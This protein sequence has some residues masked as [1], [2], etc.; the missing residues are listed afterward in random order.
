[1]NHPHRV[2]SPLVPPSPLRNGD[3]PKK[4]AELTIYSLGAD[5]DAIIPVLRTLGEFSLREL[6]R[7]QQA[8]PVT[9]TL[10]ATYYDKSNAFVA[11]LRET[12]TRFQIVFYS[13]VCPKEMNDDHHWCT[14]TCNVMQIR[15]TVGDAPDY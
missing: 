9:I 15:E 13:W 8:L 11:A 7:F 5:Q 4:N 1:M 2:V 10:P 14:G 12:G 3:P 6:A